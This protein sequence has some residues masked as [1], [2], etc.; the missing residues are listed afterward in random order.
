MEDIFR[1][2]EE[3]AEGLYKEK[4]SKFIASIHPIR[5]EEQVKQIMTDIKEM[6]Y[7]ARH[8]C[9]AFAL[10]PKRERTR[11]VDDGEPSSTAGKPILGQIVSNDLTDVLIVVVRY[12][13]GTKLGVSGLIHAYREAAIDAINN[14]TII[15]KTVDVNFTIYYGYFV[16]ND[17]MKIIKEENPIVHSREFE[18]ECK[19]EMSIRKSDSERLL[20]RL[21]AVDTLRIEIEGE[22]S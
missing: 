3:E 15:E 4:G 11:A 16:M 6:Y 17:V 7:D 22:E 9:Y 19:M 13:G 5:S 21:E 18:M 20:S 2:I 14:T 8:H 1:T 10:G 12:F